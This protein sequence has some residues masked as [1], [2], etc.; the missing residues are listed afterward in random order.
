V[1]LFFEG[2][3]RGL[4]SLLATTWVKE[5]KAAGNVAKECAKYLKEKGL[6]SCTVGLGRFSEMMPYQSWAANSVELGGGT[7]LKNDLQVDGSP[8]GVGHKA[9]YT[10]EPE[11]VQEVNILQNSVDAE[12]GHSAGG[13]VTMTMKSGTNE[14]HGNLFYITR[15]PKLSAVTDRT[16]NSFVAARNNMYGGTAGNPVLK[17]KLFNF[18]SFEQWRLREPLNFLRTMPTEL[19]RAGDFSRLDEAVALLRSALA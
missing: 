15:N 10:P 13:V 11:S 3:S 2:A 5:L 19:Q 1:V 18:F 9:S 8:I 12:S 14:W 7:N 16:L 4:P 17:N 6:V